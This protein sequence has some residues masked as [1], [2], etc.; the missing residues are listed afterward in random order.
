MASP[1]ASVASAGR[2]ADELTARH[3]VFMTPNAKPCASPTASAR[4]DARAMLGV[5]MLPKLTPAAQ[6]SSAI[7][8]G[9]DIVATAADYGHDA[10]RVNREE[11]PTRSLKRPRNGLRELYLPA[12]TNTAIANVVQPASSSSEQA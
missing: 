7:G 10:E 12:A 2:R 9:P 3:A 6:T 4:C 8:T 11:A 5:Y 1:Y